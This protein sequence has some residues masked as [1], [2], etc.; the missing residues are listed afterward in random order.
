MSKKL[1]LP[2][3]LLMELHI[4][5]LGYFNLL[6]YLNQCACGKY[7]NTK[8]IINFSLEHLENK[9]DQVHKFHHVGKFMHLIHSGYFTLA[10]SV[11][12]SVHRD[13][14]AAPQTPPIGGAQ[15]NFGGPS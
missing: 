6:W 1:L 12:C 10:S 14:A 15:A 5:P 7:V 13:V 8:L 4:T 11:H 2:E 3:L 9:W